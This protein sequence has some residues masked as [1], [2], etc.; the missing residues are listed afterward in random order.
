MFLREVE[1]TVIL[2]R[3][4]H[5]RTSTSMPELF[6][7][8]SFRVDYANK[9]LRSAQFVTKTKQM[10]VRNVGLPTRSAPTERLD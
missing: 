7:E 5:E 3:D 2:S 6:V 8:S 9:K 10:K 1:D 4:R